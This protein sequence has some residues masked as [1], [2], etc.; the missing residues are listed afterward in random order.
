MNPRDDYEAHLRDK[1]EFGIE[2]RNKLFETFNE[3]A[4]RAILERRYEAASAFQ[5]AA[6]MSMGMTFFVG[7]A[8]PVVK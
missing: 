3:L 6:S 7:E 8:R 4:D 2:I 5:F 1:A